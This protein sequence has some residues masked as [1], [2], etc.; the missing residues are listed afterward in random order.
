MSKFTGQW[1]EFFVQITF[2]DEGQLI[3]KAKNVET[4]KSIIDFEQSD[5]DM[6]R[7]ESREDFSRPKW[8]IYR[9]LKRKESLRAEEEKARFADFEIRKGVLE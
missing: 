4:G 7:G 2:A 3:V 1:V 6:W 9:S 5:I 8:G